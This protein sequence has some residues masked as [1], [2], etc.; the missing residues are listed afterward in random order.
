MTPPIPPY[1]PGLFPISSNSAWKG[2][3]PFR[4]SSSSSSSIAVVAQSSFQA[5]QRTHQSTEKGEVSLALS[6]EKD[7][8][9]LPMNVDTFNTI[10]ENLCTK[11]QLDQALQSFTRISKGG[12]K[13]N[14]TSYNI[15]LEALF[16]AKRADEAFQLIRTWKGQE[17]VPP[18]TAPPVVMVSTATMCTLEQELEEKNRLHQQS[19]TQMKL[20]LPE[21]PEPHVNAVINDFFRNKCPDQALALFKT[22][23]LPLYL[24]TLHVMIKGYCNMDRG[25]DAVKFVEYL[26]GRYDLN[27][28][29]YSLMINA[30]VSNN[31]IDLAKN[32]F[33]KHFRE[34]RWWNKVDLKDLRSRGPAFIR[35]LLFLERKDRAEVI[36]VEANV[37]IP[38]ETGKMQERLYLFVKNKLLEMSESGVVVSEDPKTPGTM[39]VIAPVYK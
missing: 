30:Y 27:F 26:Q 13:P 19:S 4:P 31:Q 28:V 9:S 2:K 35:T 6:R 36:T 24:T 21:P 23:E 1:Q 37:S 38:G 11:G 34:A 22:L 8:A 18:I 39:T 33:R 3:T 16:K 20:R 32:V 29:S 25:A 10:I 15:L 5:P 14:V 12:F 17:A 7:E